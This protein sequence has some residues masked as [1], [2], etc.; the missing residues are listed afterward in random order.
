MRGQARGFFGLSTGSLPSNFHPHIPVFR[1]ELERRS[2]ASRTPPPEPLSP[3]ESDL[4]EKH[5]NFYLCLAQGTRQ[6]ETEK[7]RHFVLVCRGDAAPQTFHER[8][9]LKWQALQRAKQGR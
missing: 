2:R 6:P 3:I 9:F 8:A 1:N 7:Q 4:I 5:L